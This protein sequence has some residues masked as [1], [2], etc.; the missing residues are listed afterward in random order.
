[1]PFVFDFSKRL[2]SRSLTPVAV[3]S[4]RFSSGISAAVDFSTFVSSK[5]V[6]PAVFS[7]GRILSRV[8]FVGAD[9]GV[10][11]ISSCGWLAVRGVVG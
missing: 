7:I 1:M 11:G 5:D 9:R 8:V 3:V 10:V 4:E 6:S 2:G